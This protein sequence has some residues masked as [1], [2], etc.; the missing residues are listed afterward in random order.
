M[1]RCLVLLGLLFVFA[2]PAAA[3]HSVALSW[4]APTGTPIAASYNMYR[5]TGACA[6]GI[7]FTKQN[8]SPITGTTYTDSTSTL[9]ANGVFCYQV[10]AVS[11]TNVE[12]IPSNQV[13]AAIPGPTAPP[14]NLVITNV[15]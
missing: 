11:P 1:K 8:T 15:T 2:L 12:S 7:V 9:V 6:T 14:T 5:A 10:T 4:T 3:Q 13:T